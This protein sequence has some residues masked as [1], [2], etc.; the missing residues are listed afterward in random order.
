MS[1]SSEM[2]LRD[3]RNLA[4]TGYD[5]PYVEQWTKDLGIQALWN[6]CKT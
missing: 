4:S 5:A 6:E 3:V 2:Q 1:R